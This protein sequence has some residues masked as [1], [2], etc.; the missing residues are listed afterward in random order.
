MF[1]LLI[2]SLMGACFCFAEGYVSVPVVATL[3]FLMAGVFV[4]YGFGRERPK[5]QS[6][7]GCFLFMAGT[8]L[9]YLA[10]I[11]LMRSGFESV[12]LLLPASG[13]IVTAWASRG[14]LP[15]WMLLGLLAWEGTLSALLKPFRGADMLAVLGLTTLLFVAISGLR[16]KWPWL[17]E[18]GE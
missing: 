1:G 4:A 11:P 15:L 16:R 10:L 9:L 3:A 8:L 7:S 2:G 18:P 12:S 6:C 13:L 17:E 5:A 14:G